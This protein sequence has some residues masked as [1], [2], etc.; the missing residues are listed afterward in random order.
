MTL[1][2]SHSPA[3]G[4]LQKSL[5]RRTNQIYTT[6]LSRCWLAELSLDADAAAKWT[7]FDLGLRGSHIL[8]TDGQVWNPKPERLEVTKTLCKRQKTRHNLG[9]HWLTVRMGSISTDIVAELHD[10]FP[11]LP[12]RGSYPITLQS[13][14]RLLA[15]RA[16]SRSR[17]RLVLPTK[18]WQ[19]SAETGRW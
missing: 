15:H 11:L 19:E 6:P 14:K 12:V 5:G 7:R 17:Y 4:I 18:C 13:R 3:A 16:C 10:I 9:Y 1:Y 8:L 2:H